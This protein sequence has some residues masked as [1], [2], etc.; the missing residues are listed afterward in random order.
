MGAGPRDFCCLTYS[1][2]LPTRTSKK[3]RDLSQNKFFRDRREE[4]VRQAAWQTA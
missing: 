1:G 4:P 2:V 3:G